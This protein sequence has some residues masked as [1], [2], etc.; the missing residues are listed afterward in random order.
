MATKTTGS[1]AICGYPIAAS[2]EGESVTCP[3]CKTTNIAQGVT[4]PN[5][6]LAGGIGLAVGIIAGPAIMAS[7]E[8]GQKWLEKQVRER[9]R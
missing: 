9:V 8:T 4:I 2:Y 3:N 6:L 1:C 7:T 5:W